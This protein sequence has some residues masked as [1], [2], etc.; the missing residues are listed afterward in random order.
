MFLIICTASKSAIENQ[1]IWRQQENSKS[2]HSRTLSERKITQWNNTCI[3]GALHIYL[4]LLHS[5]ETPVLNVTVSNWPNEVKHND[6][7]NPKKIILLH[8]TQDHML[9]NWQKIISSLAWDVLACS[10]SSPDTVPSD[11][12]LFRSLQ[13]TIS[14]QQ[15]R[16][17]Q[18]NVI[19]LLNAMNWNPYLGIVFICQIVFLWR[20]SLCI[21]FFLKAVNFCTRWASCKCA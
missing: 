2:W 8:G 15:F 5:G 20:L 9:Q 3:T 21:F 12:H 10:D 11:F 18:Q 4:E 1:T 13:H 14:D 6:Y 7:D 17:F 19:D 16:K